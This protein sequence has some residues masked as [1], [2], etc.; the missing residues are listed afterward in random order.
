M[1]ERAP[2]EAGPSGPLGS[3]GSA[4]ASSQTLTPSSEKYSFSLALDACVAALAHRPGGLVTD[5]DGTIAP[6]VL[7]PSQSAVR[8]GCREALAVLADNLD[9]VGVLTG[10][11]PEVART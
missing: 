5:V 7:D 3:A 6:I 4:V 1:S 8:P 10:R 11:E 9:F 2:W